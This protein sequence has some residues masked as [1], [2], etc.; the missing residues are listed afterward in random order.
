M[1]LNACETIP[2]YPN[3]PLGAGNYNH[4]AVLPKPTSPEEPVILLAFSGGGSRAAALALAV[5]DELR[6]YSFDE[7]GQRSRLVDHIKVISSVSGGSVTSA[8]FGL[9]GPDGMDALK[10]DFL[11]KDNMATLEW[12]AADPIT[13]VRLTFSNYTRIDALRD[14]LDERLFHGKRFA[15]F[16]RP[17]APL[18]ILNATDM[19]SGEVFAFT[20]QHFNDICSDLGALPISVGVAASAAFP[21]ALSP[22]SLKVYSGPNCVGAIPDDSWI[23]SDLTL[24]G[25]RYLNIEEFKQARYSNALRHGPDAF[26]PIDYL[27]LLDGGLVDNQGVHSL[28]DVVISPHGPIGLLDAINTGRVKR[29]VIIAINAR[30]DADNGV[31]RQASVPSIIEEVSTVTGAPIDATTA[32]AN[33][34]LKLLAD[35]LIQAGQDAKN[36]PGHP[37][38]A[39]LTVY[40]ISIDFDQFRDNQTAL[41]DRV[42]AIGTSWNLSASE[43]NDT[44]EAG[45]ILLDQHPCFQRL[46]YDLKSNATIVDPNTMQLCPEG[47]PANQ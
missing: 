38:F 42:K 32:Y 41:R 35:T 4:E 29:V 26:R 11:L 21:V 23:K 13:W 14:L 45:R 1:T 5:L 10:D 37:K 34:S 30:A 28:M 40:P 9:V 27:H 7:N 16:A 39:G 22:M 25:P 36:A 8:W 20:T 46:L 2:D 33:A 17:G 47:A 31:G 43:L 24:V 18:V 3:Q 44:M 12:T 19:A 15:D 6:V